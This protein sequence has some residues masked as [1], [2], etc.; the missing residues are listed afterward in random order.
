MCER[1]EDMLELR[2]LLVDSNSADRC[3][4]RDLLHMKR[5]EGSLVCIC[6]SELK[7]RLM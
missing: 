1:E 3:I 2:L 7:M 5:L 6:S 4:G